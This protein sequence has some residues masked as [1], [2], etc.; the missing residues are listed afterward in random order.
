MAVRF[1][2]RLARFK[3]ASLWLTLLVG[4]PAFAGS[5]L[6]ASASGR[7]VMDITTGRMLAACAVVSG[8]AG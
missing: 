6:R 8:S 3:V 4:K 2:I 1:A 7:P 5:R